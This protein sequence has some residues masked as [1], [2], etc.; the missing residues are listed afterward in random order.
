MSNGSF[1]QR[2]KIPTEFVSTGEAH[3]EPPWY[4]TNDPAV[5]IAWARDYIVA[6]LEQTADDLRRKADFID[7]KAR[8]LF[9][10]MGAV[11]ERLKRTDAILTGEG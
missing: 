9:D 7:G 10:M 1:S 4:E 3:L 2:A 8:L 11:V 5:V 6:D